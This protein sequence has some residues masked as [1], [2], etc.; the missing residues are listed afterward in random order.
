MIVYA[1]VEVYKG[2]AER[3]RV[4]KTRELAETW[5]EKMTEPLHGRFACRSGDYENAEDGM[6]FHNTLFS[7][8]T[9]MRI[10]PV[11]LEE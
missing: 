10:E 6:Y 8:N 11:E 3:I 1:G 9:E 5:F 4:F 2:R 7:G